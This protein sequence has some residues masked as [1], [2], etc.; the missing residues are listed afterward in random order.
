LAF[1]VLE[2]RAPGF[3]SEA[4]FRHSPLTGFAHAPGVEATWYRYEDG[5]RQ[6]VRTNGF[7]FADVERT[8]AKR[9]PRIALV[10]DSTTQFWETE[11]AER[12]QHLLEGLLGGRY[13]V[14]NFGVRGFGTDQ[15]YLTFREV[16]VRFAPDVVVFTFC[17][18][19][20]NDDARREGKPYFTLDAAAPHGVRL[21]GVPVPELPRSERSLLARLQQ[22]SFVLR[23][24]VRFAGSWLMPPP[25]LSQ[26]FELRLYQRELPADE[27]GRMQLTLA[28]IGELARFA[29]SRGMRFL[30]VEGVL[31][32]AY[33][34]AAGARVRAIYGD[35]F[36][37]DQV[38]RELARFAAERGIPLL[39]LPRRWR[40]EGVP[41]EAIMHREDNL[42]LNG[43]GARLY[44]RAVAEELRRLGWAAW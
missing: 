9:R 27:R 43:G 13:E 18:N 30:L 22:R 41:I 35:V 24:L 38:S 1:F 39:S 20:P 40:A 29:Q 23:R 36:D 32:Q 3:G 6:R 28:L 25:P 4:L 2:R 11:E 15:S 8:L 37:F 7:G 16:G 21:H 5:T 14:L 10:G 42:H 26:H 44:A 34:E 33:D 17:V 12:P 19:D 31:R